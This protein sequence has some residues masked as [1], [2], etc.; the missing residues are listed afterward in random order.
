MVFR[1]SLALSSLARSD[2]LCRPW[3][4]VLPEHT[5][6]LRSVGLGLS[7]FQ[8]SQDI[9]RRPPD[10]TRWPLLSVS[11]DQGPTGVCALAFAQRSLCVN[12]EEI[13]DLNHSVWNCEKQTIRDVGLQGWLLLMLVTVNVMDGPWSDNGRYQE[14]LQA[15]RALLSSTRPS[16]CPL[17]LEL[18]PM[19]C[20]ERGEPCDDPGVA[21]RVWQDLQTD[22]PLVRKG[23]KCNLNRFFGFIDT[24]TKEIPVFWQKL[25]VLLFV[26]LEMN[27]LSGAKKA[28]R[29]RMPA[30]SAERSADDPRVRS[31][32]NQFNNDAQ[33]V[34]AACANAY[35]IATLMH[36]EPANLM[37]WKIVLN[38]GKHNKAW[39]GKMNKSLRSTE[40]VIP[41]FQDQ[42]NGS[43]RNT[44]EKILATTSSETDLADIGFTLPRSGCPSALTD[45]EV[46]YEDGMARLFAQY[47]LMLVGNRWVR[48]S[49]FLRGW[50]HRAV[51]LLGSKDNMDETFDLLKKD[52]ENFT[53]LK[54]EFGEATR[55]AAAE[56]LARHPFNLVPCQQ[57]IAIAR[58]SNWELTDEFAEWLKTR[59]ARISQTQLVEDGFNRE[60]RGA[61]RSQNRNRREH[62]AFKSLIDSDLIG[63]VHRFKKPAENDAMVPRGAKLDERCFRPDSSCFS[64]QPQGL[65]TYQQKPNFYSPSV[66]RLPVSNLDLDMLS[67]AVPLDML[68]HLDSLWLGS[69]MRPE[70]DMIVR[71]RA[72]ASYPEGEWLVPL[73]HLSG[74]TTLFWPVIEVASISGHRCWRLAEGR[75]STGVVL[76]AV[77]SLEQW[78][79]LSVQ[80]SAPVGLARRLRLCRSHIGQWSILACSS[81]E[82]EPII[83]I[84]AKQAFWE[85]KKTMLDQICRY[86]SIEIEP[87]SS[88]F[89]TLWAMLCHILPEMEQTDLLAVASKRLGGTSA[90][91]DDCTLQ[92]ILLID[93]AVACLDKAEESEVREE[94]KKTRAAEADRKVYEQ[95][96]RAQ[97]VRVM[98]AAAAAPS[99]SGRKGARS[100]GVGRG[101]SS[102]RSSQPARLRLPEG[103]LQQAQIK[104]LVPPNCSIW[105][106]NQQGSWQGHCEPFK[107]V[108]ASWHLWGH[109]FSAVRVLRL[110]WEQHLTLTGGSIPEDCPIEGLFSVQPAE[111][112]AGAVVLEPAEG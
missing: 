73:K 23:F 64:V 85:L 102:S 65:V 103:D 77:W 59:F 76:Q 36:S 66:A 70:H 29:I 27:Y 40:D 42:L 52:Y 37:R 35:S 96:Y 16:Q 91:G 5:P 101:S 28:S 108:S 78:E 24:S 89:E 26:S 80:W 38:C 53:R 4:T 98:A 18:L 72:T 58:Q 6:Q 87:G 100:K 30:V 83:R 67:E 97:R 47:A 3:H 63:E 46:A 93:E 25:F 22:G 107:R 2:P 12:V 86:A 43:F 111:A 82:P 48:E 41:F 74:T 75:G 105:R 20:Q 54:D 13:Y 112:E 92:E 90:P 11:I 19:I 7:A 88:E 94:Q 110:L 45:G 84:A 56:V 79:G 39:Q 71:L 10:A 57:L 15:M 44:M 21:E 95:K 49:W 50:P 109:R 1:G 9:S 33:A 14:S 62:L 99:S 106:A 61:K 34:R 32:N 104:H 60:K 68:H 8:Q 17:F 55:G 31:T 51:M 69:F 81:G